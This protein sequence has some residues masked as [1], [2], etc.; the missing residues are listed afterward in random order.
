[1]KKNKVMIVVI[2]LLGLGMVSQVVEQNIDKDE[3]KT[4]IT[5]N[6]KE[7]EARSDETINFEKDEGT[8]DNFFERIGF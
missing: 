7:D 1:M 6:F 2:S 3:I 8:E 4:V 5:S